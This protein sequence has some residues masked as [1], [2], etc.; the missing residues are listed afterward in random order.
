MFTWGLLQPVKCSVSRD[1][2]LWED[3]EMSLEK[4][5]RLGRKLQVY[6]IY[7]WADEANLRSKVA[8]WQRDHPEIEIIKTEIE[9]LNQNIHHQHRTVEAPPTCVARIEMARF[10]SSAKSSGKKDARTESSLW[11][12]KSFLQFAKGGHRKEQVNDEI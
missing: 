4:V 6:E 8:K 9:K 12:P 10:L 11:R 3:V 2:I 1:C 7:G 5:A